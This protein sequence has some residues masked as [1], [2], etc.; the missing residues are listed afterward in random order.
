MATRAIV[1][2]TGAA[3]LLLA[4]CSTGTT[5]QSSTPTTSAR[6]SSA[7]ASTAPAAPTSAA[8]T[9][10]ATPTA[11]PSATAST[12]G[13]PVSFAC[14]DLITDQQ[15]YEY[16]PN[17]SLDDDWAP[18]SGSRQAQAVS[19]RGVACS[20]VNESSKQRINVSVADLDAAT[21]SSL[22]KKA[23]AG[24]VTSY[25]YFVLDGETGRADA[26]TGDYWITVDSK[27]FFASDDPAPLVADVAA[28]VG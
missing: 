15:I 22:K 7:P 18:A 5:E 9:S 8:P 23:K 28:A 10:S 27:A 20:W 16:N 1:L 24:E 19:Y 6:P 12:I 25:G 11:T 26:F 4:G 3:A 2:L 14:D 13:T 17:F 21:L